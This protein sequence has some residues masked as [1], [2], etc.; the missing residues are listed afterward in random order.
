MTSVRHL[1]NMRSRCIRVA[2]NAR[3]ER[4][5]EARANAV[6][7]AKSM[8]DDP[9][10]YTDAEIKAAC[11]WF[12]GMPKSDRDDEGN[13][14]YQRADQLIYSV[15]LRQRAA[16]DRQKFQVT[17]EHDEIRIRE[18]VISLALA[19]QFVVVGWAFIAIVMW[20]G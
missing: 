7:R 14:Y 1:P 5:A 9:R 6:K 13:V 15:H 16:I 4:E 17:T 2:E 12:M 8:M 11:E 10:G 20:I 18:L 19:I 3:A